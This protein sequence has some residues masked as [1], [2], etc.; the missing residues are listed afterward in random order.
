MHL[1]PSAST[2]PESALFEKPPD[3]PSQGRTHHSLEIPLNIGN[4]E[5]SI[6]DDSGGA[7]K[8]EPGGV[9]TLDDDPAGLAIEYP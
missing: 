6:G 9:A 4:V 7:P 8:G 2:D 3:E 1:R 5:T